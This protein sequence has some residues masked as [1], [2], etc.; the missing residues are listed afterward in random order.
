[1]SACLQEAER[2]YLLW[3]ARQVADQQGS[4]TVAVVGGEKG[5]QE[6]EGE[7]G[8]MPLDYA[9]HRLKKDLFPELM[10]YMG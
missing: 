7:E 4:G 10:E 9:V 8:K 1:L 2:A 5:E 6:D 3:K